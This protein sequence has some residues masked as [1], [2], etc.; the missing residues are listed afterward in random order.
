MSCKCNKCEDNGCLK[1]VPTD[2]VI[3]TKIFSCLGTGVGATLTA[4]LDKI[5]LLCQT[6]A[7]ISAPACYTFTNITFPA[8]VANIQLQWINFSPTIYPGFQTAQYSNIVQCVGNL[9]GAISTFI[10]SD[11]YLDPTDGRL[12]ST[13]TTLPTAPLL[14]RTY[15]VTVGIV[16]NSVPGDKIRLLSGLLKVLSTGVVQLEFYPDSAAVY[17]GSGLLV[18]L[19]LDGIFYE[20]TP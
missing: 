19:A 2:C 17:T 15:S 1:L 20:T 8:P 3:S 16:N 10:T 4:V 13:I 5:E 11:A 7:G 6:V 14:N 12:V 18:N 9:R